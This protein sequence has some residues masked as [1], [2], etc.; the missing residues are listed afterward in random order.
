MI[1]QELEEQHADTYY[2]YLCL[3]DLIL[4]I[5]DQ[6]TETTFLPHGYLNRAILEDLTDKMQTV[7]VLVL[8]ESKGARFVV[9]IN[10]SCPA[11]Q[12]DSTS[13]AE[14]LFQQRVCRHTIFQS[15]DKDGPPNLLHRGWH[16]GP[17]SISF[18][19]EIIATT[20]PVV[21]RVGA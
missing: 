18:S 8:G 11:P 4:I 15:S 20:I 7:C 21:A 1:S 14:H 2:L 17:L 9:G 10:Q 3:L 12:S 19:P 13:T 5:L 16:K 6:D